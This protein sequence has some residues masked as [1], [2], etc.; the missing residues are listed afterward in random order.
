MVG[1]IVSHYRILA[2]LG[3]GGMGIVYKAEDT[4]LDR[5]VALKFLPPHLAASEQDKARFIQEAKA[6][7]ALNHPNV[8]TI[9]DIQEHDGRM[10][11]VM[12]FVD[13][14]TLQ[15]KKGSLSLKQALDVGIQIADGLAAAHE[16]GIVHRDIKPENIMIRKDGIAQIMDFGLAK[17][18]ASGSKITRLTKEGSTVGTAGYMSPEQVQGQDADHR[19]D[20]FSFGVL[21]YEL[22]T[23][24]LPFKGVHESALLYEI[25]NVDA[26]P[27]SSVKQGIDPQLDEVVLD[28]LEKDPKERCQSVAEVARDLRRLRTGTGRQG[29]S[30]V[31]PV[32]VSGG[33]ESARNMSV[34]GMQKRRQ[35]FWPWLCG[36]LS[37]ALVALLV[38]VWR[39]GIASHPVIRLGI[40]FP[41]GEAAAS[42]YYSS[43]AISPD[44]TQF[45]YRMGGRLCK[46]SMNSFT[47]EAI[48][49]TDGGVNPFYSPDGRWIGFYSDGKLKKVS[50]SGG[51]PLDVSDVMGNRGAAWTKDGRIVFAP[52]TRGGLVW[53]SE[54]GGSRHQLTTIDSARHERTHRWPQILPDG[55]TVLFTVG[56]MD[57]PDYYEDA[58]IAAVNIETGERKA[59]MKGA[60]T[61]Y[62]LHTGHLLYSHAGMLFAAPFD[63]AQCEVKGTAFPVLDSVS[64]DA[65]IGASNY[66]VAGNGSLAYVPGSSG[67]LNRTLVLVDR[68]GT[69]STLP[70]PVQAYM[71]LHVSPDGKRVAVAIG[72]AKLAKD[73]DIWLYDMNGHSMSRFTFGGINRSPVWSPD[74][75]RI[76]Y[77]S[78]E[79]G[80]PK[81]I[82]R[83]ADGSGASEEI[84]MTYD[85]TY[86]MCWS[87]DGSMII[88]SG[89]RDSSGEDILVL[90]MNGDRRPWVFLGSR[91]DEA[92]ASLSPDGRWLAYVS[93]ESG[94]NQV[95]VRPFP[96]GEGKWQISTDMGA[97]AS[98]SSDGKTLFYKSQS[99]LRTVGI[100]SSKA[101]IVGE[102][103]VLVKDFARILFESM[104][105]FDPTP[106]GKYLI[107]TR[108]AEGNDTQQINVVVN[109]FEEVKQKAG[110]YR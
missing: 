69:L 94:S 104:I 9:H 71:E 91:F 19:S 44:G 49:G 6:A 50:L 12:E 67:H 81:I 7:S 103:R 3:E 63:A 20:I 74:S 58:T 64:G 53:S 107:C 62:Y 25:V 10:F 92:Q 45:V 16:K 110:T 97:E 96:R 34:S 41:K 1:S 56:T 23:G 46:R 70:V 101:M 106:D 80:N 57:S 51:M 85:R 108:T 11:I 99:E 75:R 88:F 86:L 76:A 22:F 68:N 87:R 13:G 66:A 18:R 35:P 77:S 36:A 29:V 72:S 30:R 39:F 14:Q 78:N 65:I 17:L 26:S 28:C 4:K 98:W 90:P 2:K 21:L 59:V 15:E 48:P 27:M 5:I 82:I 55:K 105:D 83:D 40:T 38:V 37:I 61:A 60:S 84:P 33:S 32:R 89:I 102:T 52:A 100:A 8:C 109:W 24:Q 93:N 95:Y 31:A 47:A 42:Q 43:I 54:D 79:A 73:H